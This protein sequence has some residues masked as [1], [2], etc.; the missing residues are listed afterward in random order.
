[1]T[2][3]PQS[4]PKK[5]LSIPTTKA[6]LWSIVFSLPPAFLFIA[7]YQGRWGIQLHISSENPTAFL[8]TLLFFLTIIVLGSILHELIHGFTWATFS[9]KP[10]SAIKFGFQWKT[11][12][13][14][15]HCREPMKIAAYRLG[16]FMPLL[17][18]GILPSLI[19][20]VTGN[21]WIMFYGVLFTVA[22]GGDMLV[23]WLIRGV[24][25]GQLVED[26]PSQ[27]GCYLIESQPK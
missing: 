7:L 9:H 12:T 25:S 24:K 3:S 10:L 1:M 26:H 23:L 6:T 2:E 5:D 20:I 18:T 13:P 14:Y 15:A 27:A 21:G 19:G 8:Y 4:L 17:V 11:L 22:A 16:G